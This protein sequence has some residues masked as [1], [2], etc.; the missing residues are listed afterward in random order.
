MKHPNTLYSLGK[1][2]KAELGFQLC[3]T[4][5]HTY[6]RV[7]TTLRTLAFLKKLTGYVGVERVKCVL[8][9]GSAGKGSS[10]IL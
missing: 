3:T 4:K 6:T 5:T 8:E 9:E 7:S 2:Q 10:L 1:S